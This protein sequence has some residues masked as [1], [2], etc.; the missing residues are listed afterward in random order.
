[1]SPGFIEP[2]I[3][4]QDCRLVFCSQKFNDMLQCSY[5]LKV[6][7]FAE[8]A[9][10]KD[11]FNSPYSFYSYSSVSSSSPDFVRLRVGNVFFNYMYGNNICRTEVTEDFTCP[12]CLMKC[13]NFKAVP[14]AE[15][16][17]TVRGLGKDVSGRPYP[18]LCNAGR[19]RL[20]PRTCWLQAGLEY[21]LLSSHDLFNFEFKIS[22]KHQA[23]NVSLKYHNRTAKLFPE[24]VDP[25][26]GTFSYFSKYKKYGRLLAGSEMIY[27][28]KATEM[29]APSETTEVVKSG[30][31]V[32]M[33]S[34]SL[35]YT[36]DGFLGDHVQKDN[37]I[38]LAD[39]SV[40]PDYSLHGGSL[41]TQK[42]MSFEEVLSDH[43]SEGE[44]DDDVVDL[45]ERTGP[46]NCRVLADG[47]IPWAC[48]AFS[49]LHGQLLVQNPSL[50]LCWRLFMI[51]LWNHNLLD[52][53]TMD[54]C[55]RI[56][57]GIQSKFVNGI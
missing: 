28:S 46:V 36:Q 6:S 1:M 43:D 17:R 9:G 15:S 20:E 52:A 4:E 5:H 50:R 12:F 19:P 8:E 16:S 49:E 41:S 21:H 48:K 26:H 39:V 23:V 40:A 31:L 57:D 13:G 24:A 18:R 55:N 30:Q 29:I 35:E 33:G 25:R 47:H 22:E 38:F 54:T 14:S 34:K 45:E 37:G 32:S 44:I 42:K 7:I 53:R 2:D 10:A 11:I 3:L 27:P 51:K 56:L